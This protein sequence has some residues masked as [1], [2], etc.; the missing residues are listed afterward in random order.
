ML[1]H[2]TAACAVG[3]YEADG[4]NWVLRETKLFE[5]LT[6]FGYW[7]KAELLLRVGK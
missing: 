3:I 4:S 6:T 5:Q 2:D 7:Q 1:D